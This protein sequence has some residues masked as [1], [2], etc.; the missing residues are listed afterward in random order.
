LRERSAAVAHDIA[1][2]VDSARKC[3]GG[4][5]NI[6]GNECPIVEEKPVFAE[7]GIGVRADN[8]AM[9]VDAMRFSLFRG[10]SRAG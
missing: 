10:E 8:V 4:A 6:Y 9:G 1:L 3:E 5:G 7:W 2:I